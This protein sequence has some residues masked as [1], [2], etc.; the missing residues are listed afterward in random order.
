V[1][2]DDLS[3][4]LSKILPSEIKEI[5]DRRG[6]IVVPDKDNIGLEIVNRSLMI[7]YRVAL[8]REKKTVRAGPWSEEYIPMETV[9]VSTALCRNYQQKDANAICNEFKAEVK[10]KTIF[11]GGKETIGKGLV[12]IIV[13]EL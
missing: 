8:D 11:V 9:F 7:Q 12:K 10:D 1:K 6:L 3:S 5:I 4:R 2:R 13:Y